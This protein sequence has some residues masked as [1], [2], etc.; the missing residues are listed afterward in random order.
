M[1]K[2]TSFSSRFPMLSMCSLRTA[3]LK[4]ALLVVAVSLCFSV[5]AEAQDNKGFSIF[6][7]A[8]EAV[9]S[10]VVEATKAIETKPLVVSSKDAFTNPAVTLPK[11]QFGTFGNQGSADLKPK[12]SGAKAIGTYAHDGRGMFK[13]APGQNSVERSKLKPLRSNNSLRSEKP[14]ADNDPWAATA[15]APIVGSGLKKNTSPPPVVVGDFQKTAQRLPPLPQSPKRSLQPTPTPRIAQVAF[16]EGG[17]KPAAQSGASGSSSAASRFGQGAANRFGQGNSTANRFG[18]GARGSQQPGQ[19]PPVNRPATQTQPRSGYQGL[20]TG[21]NNPVQNNRAQSNPVQNVRAQN[22]SGQSNVGSATQRGRSTIGSQ[23]RRAG[24][25]A[26]PKSNSVGSKAA[27]EL[28][29]RWVEPREETELPGKQLK[30]HEFLA[31]AT[32]GSRKDAINQYWV[33]FSDLAKH[34][35]AIEQAQW[36]NSIG[37][38]RQQTDQAVLKAA[39]QTAQNRV[40]HT[41]IQLAKSQAMLG[42]YLPN[43]RSTS[44]KIV[45]VLPSSIPWVGKLNTMFDEYQKRGM[46]PPRFNSIDSVLPKARQLISNRADAVNASA[47]AADQAKNAMGSGQTGVANV[48]EAAR[49]KIQNENEFLATVEGYNRS[50]TDYVLSVRQDI[51]EP[52]RLTSVL[53]GR[54]AVQPTEQLASKTERPQEDTDPLAGRSGNPQLQQISTARMQP[55][56]DRGLP[57]VSAYKGSSSLGGATT[58]RSSSQPSEDVAQ[59]SQELTPQRQSNSHRFSQQPSK[60]AVEKFEY[61]PSPESAEA[62]NFDP[63]KL[64]EELPMQQ[65]QPAANSTYPGNSPQVASQRSQTRPPGGGQGGVGQRVGDRRGQAG[66]ASSSNPVNVNSAQRRTLNSQGGQTTAGRFGGGAAAAAQGRIPA[67]QSGQ[68]GQAQPGGTI[69]R[70]QVQ[71]FAPTGSRSGA[72]V[73]G[74]SSPS[75][76]SNPPTKTGSPFSSTVRPP[77]DPTAATSLGSRAKSAFGG[78]IG[79]GTNPIGG[80]SSPI[81]GGGTFGGSGAQPSGPPVS[82]FGSLNGGATR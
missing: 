52:K 49:I 27:K 35:L 77:S 31:Q 3:F 81:A 57:G 28:L 32:N 5:S 13:Q 60:P 53:I 45:P 34:R 66:Q 18:A 21:Q 20:Q 48:L 54:K 1:S 50:I 59:Q 24:N 11:S 58:Q 39:Q 56:R 15:S 78:G 70:P 26:S 25:A 10:K 16:Q 62:A 29:T 82:R 23:D 36:L 17:F 47:R 37:S 67:G 42:D 74:G 14:Q 72:A 61:G 73:P 12:L 41:E 63:S 76:R 40:L 75:Q 7:P 2:R 8:K 44:G 65:H 79:G 68:S 38:P 22:Y 55:K 4:T 51:Y 6:E 43:V 69:P 19:R 46:I 80:G 30:L 64:R 33:T 9:E 71:T